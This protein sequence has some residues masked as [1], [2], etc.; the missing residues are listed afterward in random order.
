[1]FQFRLTFSINLF[2]GRVIFSHALQ[3][4]FWRKIITKHNFQKTHIL[5]FHNRLLLGEIT[6]ILELFLNF[7]DSIRIHLIFLEAN[8]I[9]PQPSRLLIFSRILV[10]KVV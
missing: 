7:R 9:R 1:M 8:R 6:V 2:F 4:R 3:G 10:F 5:I